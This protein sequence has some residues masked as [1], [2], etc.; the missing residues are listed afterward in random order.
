ML[1]TLRTERRALAGYYSGPGAVH[2]H[3]DEGQRHYASAVEHLK[4]RF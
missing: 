3:L 2:R 4:A 1:D